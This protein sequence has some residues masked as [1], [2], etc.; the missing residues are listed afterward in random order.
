MHRR[1]VGNPVE[2]ENLVEAEPEQVLEAGFLFPLI[3]LPA[4]E[5][6]ER[7]LPANHAID[8]LLTQGAIDGRNPGF[9]QGAFQQILRKAATGTPLP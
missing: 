7:G 3:R 5:P 9:G 8:Q 2:P 6:V 4:D 1:V